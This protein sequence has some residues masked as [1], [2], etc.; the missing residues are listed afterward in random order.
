[1]SKFIIIFAI[2]LTVSCTS[3]RDSRYTGFHFPYRPD[4]HQGNVID[5][6][7]V[8][9][10]K[11]GMDKEQVEEIIGSPIISDDFNKNHW[12]FIQ[13]KRIKNQPRTVKKLNLYF[14]EQ[15]LAKINK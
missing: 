13:I 4:M 12:I 5:L 3:N 8:T 11:V 14:E 9:K 10:L 15:K 2:F 6:S 1:M 7:L